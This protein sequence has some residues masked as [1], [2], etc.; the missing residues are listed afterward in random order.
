MAN[1]LTASDVGQFGPSDCNLPRFKQAGQYAQESKYYADKSEAIYNELANNYD[2]NQLV[3]QAKDSAMAAKVSEIA[4]ADSASLAKADADKVDA[5]VQDLSTADLVYISPLGGE[6]TLQIP[7]TFTNVR[8]LYINGSR[9]TLGDTFSFDPATHIV[10]FLGGNSLQAG[11]KVIVVSSTIYEQMSTVAQTLQ[12]PGGADYV[13]TGDGESVQKKLDQL[14]SIPSYE[15]LKK[16]TPSEV[17]QKVSLISHEVGG[18]I[19]GG[20]FVAKIGSGVVDDGGHICV[21]YNSSGWYWERLSDKVRLSD[22]N[23]YVQELNSSNKVDMSDRL[24]S[25]IN[26]S[27]NKGLVISTG[28]T[29]ENHYIKNGIYL[30]KGVSITGIKTMTGCLPLIVDSQIFTGISA[31]GYDGITWVLTNLNASYGSTGMIFGT[32]GGNQLLDSIVIR[33]ISSR[34]STLG[35]QLHTFSGTIVNGSL[36]ATGFNG[37]GVYLS[38]C[39]DSSIQDVRAISCGNTSYWGVSFDSYPKD[40]TSSTDTSNHLT[41]GSVEAHDCIDRAINQNSSSSAISHI[42]E[43]ATVVTDTSTWSSATISSNGFGWTN[44]ILAG[45]WSNYGSIRI[46]PGANTSSNYV[47]TV[48]SD[49]ISIGSL[50][51][52]GNVSLHYTFTTPRRGLN[53]GTLDIVNN[54]Y[55]TPEVFGKINHCLVRGVSSV[56]TQL[57][58]NI[59]FGTLNI[60]G[61]SSSITS[62]GG[63]FDYVNANIAT[64][65]AS[66]VK[67]G[68]FI[69]LTTLGSC[70]LSDIGSVTLTMSGSRNSLKDA[71]IS[72]SSTFSGDGII[73][74][75]SLV[76]TTNLS[77]SYTVIGIK[78]NANFSISNTSAQTYGCTI[79]DS[80][81]NGQLTIS[82][83]AKV[84]IDSVILISLNL[85]LTAGYILFGDIQMSGGLSGN[86]ISSTNIPCIGS[87][88][89]DPSNGKAYIYKSTGW[90]EITTSA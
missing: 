11:D 6:T 33:D 20:D 54:L 73:S 29:N 55:I 4:A 83:Y 81:I 89:Q 52:E 40:S 66:T 68:S 84:K 59:S 13:K 44:T 32:S 61:S 19:G 70:N 38:S 23:I 63:V 7:A 42:H 76:G 74:G 2:L 43:E 87:I 28:L 79:R 37:P 18:I 26:R 49:Q 30:T 21:P 35:A 72:G 3:Q 24:Q 34:S 51:V 85:S 14:K 47:T 80:F 41:V 57:S 67:R 16:Y 17:G 8:T 10:S 15:D 88:T 69:T 5:W 56:I 9:Q 86:A 27:I 50:N 78:T 58:I 39:Y 12:S 25:A 45:A 62:S 71:Y 36:C 64:L 82:N 46:L 75:S 65:T 31:V 77:G 22:Y 53:I 1:C 60:T 48:V 90:K